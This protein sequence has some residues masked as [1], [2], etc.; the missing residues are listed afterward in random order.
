MPPVRPD[1]P[2]I[3]VDVDKASRSDGPAAPSLAE[4]LYGLQPQGNRP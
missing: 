2:R 1:V 3:A 4:V